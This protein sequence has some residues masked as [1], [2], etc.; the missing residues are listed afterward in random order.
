MK[1][2]LSHV[3]VLDLTRLYPGAFCTQLLADLGVRHLRVLG[4]PGEHWRFGGYVQAFKADVSD[5]DA[6]FT[7]AG[8]Y[9]EYR[10]VKNVGVQVGYDWFNLK[11]DYAKTSW[12]GKL[13][14]DIRGPTAGL[15]FAF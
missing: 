4:T 14:L 10:F 3:R 13:D 12:H 2:L 11:A 6:R 15:T 8:V 5:I 7:R 9:A 1:T